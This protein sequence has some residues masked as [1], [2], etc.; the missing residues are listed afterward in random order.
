MDP[1]TYVV[2]SGPNGLVAA[3][4]LAEA[5]QRVIVLEAAAVAGGGMRTEELTLPGF[6]HDVCSSVHPLALASPAFRELDL[7]REGLTFAHPAAALGHP[8]DEHT[9]AVVY[10]DLER[11]VAEL[12]R[13][14]RAWRQIVGGVTRSGDRLVDSLLSPLDLP[15]KAPIALGGLRV[16]R[17]LAVAVGRQG[18]VP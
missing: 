12:G 3:I 7:S 10:R 4:R 17:R 9:A 16:S 15:P 18:G 5:G 11:T 6:R 8:V 2:G 13:D 1:D 14:G